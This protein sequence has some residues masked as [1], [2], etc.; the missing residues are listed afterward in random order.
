M[1]TENENQPLNSELLKSLDDLANKAL[2]LIVK[3]NGN[4]GYVIN[5]GTINVNLNAKPEPEKIEVKEPEKKP[6]VK[7]K[8]ASQPF[9]IKL[10]NTSNR[11]VKNVK[12]LNAINSI[13]LKNF[14]LPTC[15][16]V[17]YMYPGI[18]Y[19]ELLKY[20]LCNSA[21]IQLIRTH[22]KNEDNLRSLMN[23]N[24][25][26]LAGDSFSKSVV[27][28][29]NVFMVDRTVRDTCDDFYL[30]ATLSITLDKIAP[31]SDI[32][33]ELYPSKVSSLIANLERGREFKTPNVNNFADLSEK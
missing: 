8:S 7:E 20:L 18:T 17:E 30:T 16:K 12:F 10:T 4:A 31:N 3:D 2:S 5:I 14:G 33:F 27:Q 24:T 22:S 23:I 15:I 19:E 1:K 9:I 13:G 26:N 25:F 32:T 21:Q 28:F 29:N 11:T 6:E